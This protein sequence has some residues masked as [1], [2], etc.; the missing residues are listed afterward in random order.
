MKKFRRFLGVMGAAAFAALSALALAA[1][2]TKYPEVTITYEFNGQSYEVEYTLSRQ[3]A[4][5]T[6]Q[7]FIELAD[8][9][10]YDGT[11]I[12]DFK[13]SS[14]LFGG[15]YTLDEHG[16]LVEKDYFSEVRRLE[17]EKGITFT[18]SV[19]EDAE[20]KTPLYTVRGEFEKNG[21]KKNSKSLY[22]NKAG[23]LVMY[24]MDKGEDDTR[25]CTLRNDSETYQNGYPYRYN[26]ATS[27]FYTTVAGSSIYSDNEYCAFG[28]TTDYAQLEELI[29]AITA[30]EESRD[31][32]DPLFSETTVILNQHDP[33]DSVRDAKIPATYNLSDVPIT[34]VSVRVDKY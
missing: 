27:L 9:G 15:G 11:V 28:R 3:G 12:H 18:Q 2:D 30:Y 16:E 31:G 5:Q 10:Y 32:N 14:Y 13:N 7:H 6:V 21:V 1:C 24:Y 26:S 29:N 20:G 33:I 23:T 34:I 8:A 4:P 25:V 17:Q 22:Q 19:F